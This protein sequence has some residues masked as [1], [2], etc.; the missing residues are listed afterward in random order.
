MASTDALYIVDG[1][2]FVF[3]A[4][5]ALPPLTTRA[6]IPSGAVY[7]FTQMLLR[8]ELDHRPSHLVVVF[9]AGSHSFRNDLYPQYKATRVE[10]P[11]DLVP[12]FASVRRVVE[13]FGIALID[14]RGFEADDLIATLTHRAK[15]QGQRVVIV[16][17]DKDLMQ[18]VDDRCVLIDT[19]K[20]KDFVY[21]P[22]EV[23]A[24]FG[25]PPAQLG[26]LLAL[27][28]DSIDNIPGVP[29]VGP[30]TASAL[31]HHF[32]SLEALLDRT[33]EIHTIAGLRGAASVEAKVK[34]HI[35]AIRLSRR[36]VA[37]DEAVAVDVPLE[38][39]LRQPPDMARVEPLLVELE[40]TRLIERM[41]PLAAPDGAMAG[42]PS[43]I[44]SALDDAPAAVVVAPTAWRPVRLC[45][46][47]DELDALARD[48][49]A[50]GEFSMTVERATSDAPAS[51]PRPWSDALVGLAFAWQGADPVYVPLSHRY[52]GAPVQLP[53]AEVAARLGALLATHRKHV[54]DSKEA[55][56]LLGRH[57]LPFGGVI[58]DP[59]LVSYLIDPA[60]D[61]DLDQ[62]A[63]RYGFG[64]ENRGQL[65][66]TGK[67]AQAYD[68]VPVERAATWAGAHAEA[69]LLLSPRLLSALD[70]R[71]ELRKLFDDVELPLAHVLAVMEQ[72]GV[73][74]D[75]GFLRQLATEVDGQLGTLEKEVVALAGVE[76]NLGSP[77]Q[78]SE[79]L[80]DKLGLPPGRKTKTGYSTDADVLEELAP[81]HPVA[82][83]I[84]DHRVLAKL[85][86]TYIDALP[87]LVDPRSGRLHTSYRQTI[88]ATG[89]LSSTD[90]NLQNVP[91]RTAMGRQIRQ[92]FVAA[93][94][95]R[96]VVGD[97]SQI[98]LRILAH[99]SGDPVLVD[100]FVKDED[101]HART[102]VEMFGADRAAD[103]QLRSVAKMINYGI[104]YGLSDF[105]LAERLGIAR[106]DAKQYIERYLGTY[107]VLSDYMKQLITDGYRDGGARTILGRFRPLPELASKNRMVRMA[108]ERMARNTPVQGSA[109][110]MLKVAMIAVQRR[111]E[112]EQP[113]TRMLLTVHDELVLEAPVDAVAAVG[114]LLAETMER[115]FSLRVPLKV[116]RGVGIN[117]SE[118]K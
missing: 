96:L 80:F 44:E 43:S 111:L 70:A 62:I 115:V 86:G 68:G 27:M 32:G 64:L 26:D 88:A 25:V 75:V 17:S 49:A 114:D 76:L 98:E 24:K 57:G 112:S 34:T 94:G 117:W 1:S 106:G 19:M 73:A 29:G 83:K 65:L 104:V 3:R 82:Q 59:T 69:T 110:D 45:L 81:L 66:G 103:P 72:H 12:Q 77:K 20:P 37:L 52:L 11:G 22:S 100:A 21:G 79:L 30:K 95:H 56:T 105:G 36:L 102:V 2:G 108:G 28:G 90:P 113:E 18:L 48:L 6:G 107:S 54:A 67:K 87:L 91:I 8:L 78:L 42:T 47:S 55:E 74:L 14:A 61:H 93:P 118:A 60:A 7:G 116:D 13:A 85:K 53:L 5:H 109:A 16:S 9:D 50:A 89:R 39:L 4:Y 63:I 51:H 15:A 99:L 71:P 58:G 41:R 101:I 46:S 84:L 23:E 97:Y 33:D 35:D 10:P 38:S 31:I 92:A 40:F